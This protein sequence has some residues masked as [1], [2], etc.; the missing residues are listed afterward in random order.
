MATARQTRF[1]SL[2]AGDQIVEHRE[3]RGDFG[4]AVRVNL[5]LLMRLVLR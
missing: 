5:V 3:C 2:Q 1:L 4:F